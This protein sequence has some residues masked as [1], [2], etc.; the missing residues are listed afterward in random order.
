MIC[1]T[2]QSWDKYH[3]YFLKQH[4]EFYSIIWPICQA[5]RKYFLWGD[6]TYFLGSDTQYFDG[7]LISEDDQLYCPKF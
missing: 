5:L 6:T 7:D 3:A 1:S 4:G 2:S